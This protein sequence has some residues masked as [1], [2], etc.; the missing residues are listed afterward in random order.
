MLVF[1]VCLSLVVH[2]VQVRSQKYAKR[3][4]LDFGNTCSCRSLAF[5]EPDNLGLSCFKC[6][7]CIHRL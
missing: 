7:V 5:F 4:D 6:L 2:F 1:Y 3:L